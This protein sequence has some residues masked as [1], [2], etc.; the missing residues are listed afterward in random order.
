MGTLNFARKTVPSFASLAAPLYDLLKGDAVVARDW[1]A[2][3]SECLR[4]L[5][6]A[7]KVSAPLAHRKSS[8]DLDVTLQVSD[9]HFLATISNHAESQPICYITHTFSQ[10]ERKFNVVERTLTAV[11]YC[12]SKVSAL[13]QGKIIHCY[14]GIPQLQAVTRHSLPESRALSTRWVQWRADQY[15]DDVQFHYQNGLADSDIIL[16]CEDLCLTTETDRLLPPIYQKVQLVIFTDG[17]AT[18]S[19]D[20]LTAFFAGAANVILTPNKRGQWKVF[21]THTWRLGDMSSQQAE[22]IAFQKALT[23]IE[24]TPNLDPERSVMVCSDSTYVV[25]GFNSHM[26]VWENSDFLDVTGKPIAHRAHWRLIFS[27]SQKL[28]VQV[29][30]L[31]VP[32]H[33]TV[34][35]YS[36]Y[37]SLAD[38]A[39]KLAA[40]QQEITVRARLARHGSLHLNAATLCQHSDGVLTR[41]QAKKM[42]SDCLDCQR[43]NPKRTG[44][45][46][47]EGTLPRGIRPGQV[48]YM[49]HVGPLTSSRGYRHILVVLDSF[50][51]FVFLFAQ[52]RITA[53]VTV[54]RLAIVFGILPFQFLCTDGGPAFKNAEVETFCADHS[55]THRFSYPHRPESNGMVERI[56]GEVK[57]SLQ[58]FALQ[59]NP[60][61]WY[62]HLPEIQI[63]I[64][65]TITANHEAPA[66]SLFGFSMLEN[67]ASSDAMVTSDKASRSP[68][69]FQIGS[70]VLSKTHV[71]GSLEP[72]WSNPF[73]V[74]ELL[75]DSGLLLSDSE[76]PKNR[77]VVSIRDVKLVSET[78]GF[79]G[80]RASVQPPASAASAVSADANG[81]GGSAAA[82]RSQC[83]SN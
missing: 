77:K 61:N 18:P 6:E 69:P 65:S 59:S 32:A 25:S 10:P 27:I 43:T 11:R 29:L 75:G 55:V 68:N 12:L 5:Q 53:I 64:N 31:H 37:N 62:L 58:I 71:R 82:Q 56:N 79:S 20:Y 73:I 83:S 67:M 19:G 49:D 22:L 57:R 2:V 38:E 47:V 7:V 48:V 78:L 50:T 21:A 34:G 4:A 3:H 33:Q 15:R 80:T 70:V 26:K 52:K 45:P 35:W 17:S 24:Q 60:S 72:Y 30:V 8:K 40:S 39:A 76:D 66:M 51:G 54:N 36:R 13:A 81:S 63:R 9:S 16:T 28:T 46:Y 41:S 23:H 42:V 44:H 1:T 14:T 74:T